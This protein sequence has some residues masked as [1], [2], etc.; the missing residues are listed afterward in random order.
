ML[1][2]VAFGSEYVSSENVNLERVHS[3]DRESVNRGYRAEITLHIAIA[4]TFG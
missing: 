4:S 1:I 2:G 3:R